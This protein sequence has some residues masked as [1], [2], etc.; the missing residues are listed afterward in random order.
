MIDKA[1]SESSSAT[2]RFKK[3]LTA[4]DKKSTILDMVAA[5]EID[6]LLIA[7]MD[8]NIQGA[9]SA[10]EIEKADYMKKLRDACKRYS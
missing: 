8:Q 10:G 6:Q 1:V 4:K 7:F 5:N 3:L 9:E 2:D